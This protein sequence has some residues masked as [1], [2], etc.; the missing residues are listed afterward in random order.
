MKRALITGITG[1]DGSYLAEFLLNKGYEVH[2]LVRRASLEQ[3]LRIDHL[4]KDPHKKSNFK[5]HYGD[6]TDSMNVT[7]LIQ[8]IEPDEIY[9]LAAQSHVRV[10]FEIPEYTANADG[11][12]TMRVLEAI[13]ISGLTEKTRVYQASTSELYGKVQAVPQNE[14][15][16]FYP[17]SPYGV[18][19]IYAYWL[20]VN[21]REAY[22]MFASNGILFNHESPRRGNSFVTKKIAMAA[23]QIKKG[24][25]EKLYLGNLDAKRDWGYAKE[26]VES[27]WH[28]L[29]HHEGDDFVIATGETHSVR[30]FVELAFGHAGIELDWEGEG[31]DEKGVDRKTG[32]VIVAIDPWYFR[33]TEVDLL[34]GDGTKAKKLL[35]WEPKVKFE[36]L[37]GIMM[38]HELRQV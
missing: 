5:V 21:Y 15:T 19:K 14:E 3:K 20:T 11:L 17:R 29:Q 32:K 36:E 22:G 2:G 13:R 6:I 1:Q 12:G 31:V 28:I 26:Y 23:S 25:R 38:E 10:S 8:Q 7:R 34:I 18:A 35:N 9:N 37:V 27:M 4:Y 30:E 16:P 33:P 24:E